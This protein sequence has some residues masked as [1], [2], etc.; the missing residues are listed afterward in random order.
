[1]VLELL[2]SICYMNKKWRNFN[3][4]LAS[5]TKMNSKWIIDQNVKHEIISL[6][7]ENVGE[8]NLC[9]LGLDKVL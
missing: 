6:L 7:E 1:M 3:P 4:Y 9:D 2:S 8:K 5:H